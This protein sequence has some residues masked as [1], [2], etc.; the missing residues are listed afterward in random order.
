MLRPHTTTT[1]VFAPTPNRTSGCRV[2]VDAFEMI[3]D[4]LEGTD[5]HDLLDDRVDQRMQLISF[6]EKQMQTWLQEPLNSTWSSPP[7]QFD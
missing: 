5:V 2:K 1:S 3:L 4:G 7:R 6:M